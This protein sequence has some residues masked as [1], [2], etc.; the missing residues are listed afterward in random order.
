MTYFY[1]RLQLFARLSL[2]VFSLSWDFYL[3]LLDS[4]S[5]S[6]LF[7]FF[8]SLSY[9]LLAPALLCSSCPTCVYVFPFISIFLPLAVSSSQIFSC[10][11]FLIFNMPLTTVF[12]RE[13]LSLFL[14]HSFL[15]SYSVLLL[16]S[17]SRFCLSSLASSHWKFFY[18]SLPSILSHFS[19][20]LLTLSCTV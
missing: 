15:H 1:L 18:L 13:Y 3:Y 5:E 6:R 8:L 19:S 2:S 11:Y 17:F 20:R 12:Y 14:S 4:T 9:S 10:G 16:A 7:L